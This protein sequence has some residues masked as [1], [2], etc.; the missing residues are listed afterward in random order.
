[1]PLVTL[2]ENVIW[3]EAGFL[4]PLPDMAGKPLLGDVAAIVVSRNRP[5]LVEMMAGQVKRMGEALKT[6]LYVVEMGTDK[7][8]LTDNPTLWY[9]DEDFRGKCYGH[10]VGLRWVLSQGRYRYYW[11]LMNDLVFPEGEDTL[12]ILHA[13]MEENPSLAIL[14]PTEPEGGYP[15]SKPAEGG[16][17]PYRVVS[18]TDYLAILVRDEAIASA[19]F[20]NPEFKFCWGAIHELSHKLYRQGLKIAYCDKATM[21]H[22]GGT[23]YGKA[24][25]TISREKYL[26][27]AKDFAANYFIEHYGR[28]WDVKFAADLPPEA[29]SNTYSRHRKLWEAPAREAEKQSYAKQYNVE[30]MTPVLEK[31]AAFLAARKDKVVIYGAGEH[32]E[33]ILSWVPALSKTDLLA[34]ADK[35][36]GLKGHTRFGLKVVAP[37]EIA[38]LSPTVVII[39]SAAHQEEIF[40]SL[41]SLREAGTLVVRLYPAARLNTLTSSLEAGNALLQEVDDLHPWYYSLNVGSVKVVAGVGAKQSAEELEGRVSYREP[42]TVAAS[43]KRYDFTGKSVLDVASNCGYWSARLVKEGGAAAVTL[44]EGRHDYVRQGKIFWQEN[45]LLPPEDIRIVHCNVTDPAV[46]QTIMP[47]NFSL[48]LGILYHIP[49]PAGLLRL[50][51]EKTKD[52][53]LVD[54]RV[55]TEEKVVFE[56]GGWSFDAI[57]ETRKKIVPTLQNLFK[58]LEDLGFEVERMETPAPV[59][60]GLRDKD[61]YSADRRVCLF[62]KRIKGK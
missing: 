20:L 12:K 25:N 30:T 50:I 17:T 13:V 36:P 52:A 41:K 28:D 47:H 39:S 24:K 2:P 6:D 45:K 37:E 14:S 1:M 27:L 42:F 19:G 31:L 61:D 56:P 57:V 21:K 32:T 4:E 5:D 46:W 33:N 58:T 16:L 51:A 49:D 40:D 59:P 29:V 3:D 35:N 8:K 53:M 15:A 38:G 18:T 23:T 10:N 55:D 48:C 44:M 11:I 9:A 54:T 26:T 62:A 7:D 34:I 22:L 60:F 43:V